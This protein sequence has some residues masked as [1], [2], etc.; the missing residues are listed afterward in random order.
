MILTR[1]KLKVP[2]LSFTR[3]KYF[4]PGRS[5][6]GWPCPHGRGLPSLEG[7]FE[8]DEPFGNLAVKG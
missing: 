4:D 7:L 5:L 2:R 8:Q 6:N 3:A 1:K